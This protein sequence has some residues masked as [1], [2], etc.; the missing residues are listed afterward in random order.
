MLAGEA[1][2]IQQ[3][4]EEGLECFHLRKPG[5]SEQYVR[6]LLDAIPAAYHKSIALHGLHWLANDYDIRRFHFTEDHLRSLNPASKLQSDPPRK[7][8]ST[9]AHNLRTLQL[10][11]SL[12]SYTF[13]SPVFD[14]LSKPGYKGIAGD[15][16]YLSSEYKRIRVIALGGINAGNMQRVADMNF[17]GAA[18]C[19]AIW[20]EPAKA[21]EKWGALKKTAHLVK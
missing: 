8:F 4:F 16:F 1:G 20:N 2:I 21:V 19:G 18:V 10:L 9:S 11:P 5:P 12:F 3:L 13:F 6:Q 17:D 15:E 14:S 7:I